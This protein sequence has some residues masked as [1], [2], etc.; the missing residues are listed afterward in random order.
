[1][2]GRRADFRGQG[3]KM[4]GGRYYCV[5]LRGAGGSQLRAALLA[6]TALVAAGLPA[7]AQDAT[8]LAAPI[9]GDYNYPRNWSSGTVPSGTAYF[10]ASN[11]TSLS[12]YPNDETNRTDVG[13][14]T[15]NA[16][17]GNYTFANDQSL[18]FN[19]AGIVINGGS[20]TITVLDG[21]SLNFRNASTTG[22]ATINLPAYS[23]LN[24][25]NT[26]SAGNAAITT[27]GYL[28]F[29]NTSTA[30]SAHITNYGDGGGDGGGIAGAVSFRDSS[31]AG[32]AT[33]TNY[34]VIGFSD[35]STAGSAAITNNGGAAFV[36]FSGASTAG[37]ATITN[38]AH[39]LVGFYG[40]STG[41]NAA[42]IN[43]ASGRVDFSGSTGPAGDSRLS[44]GSIAGAGDFFLGARKLSVGGNNLSTEVSGVI[45]DCSVSPPCYAAGATGGSLVKTGTG[46]LTLSGV[47]TYTGATTV[48]GGIL[49]VDGSIA[50]SALTSVNGGSLL[51]GTGTVGDT[52]VNSGGSLLGGNG[53]AGA[54]LAISGN[55]AFQSG[56][57]YL[58]AV[59]PATAS[60]TSVTG[61][62]TLGGATVNAVFAPRSYISKKY[63]ILTA[64]GG[65]SGTFAAN[66]VNTNLPANFHTALSYDA[67]HAYLDLTLNYFSIPGGLNQNQQAWATR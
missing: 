5:G 18:N 30:G 67:T 55:L 31:T 16:G 44:V 59:N 39:S 57:M 20:A 46:T 10:G 34:G 38:N 53:T 60:F 15:F 14:W 52:T 48:D 40:T 51:M 24:F 33:I 3:R 9:N 26:G 35:T 27:Y 23:G 28:N 25:Y 56:A 65:V 54:S 41:G 11:I 12:L 17:A 37:N 13:G 7:A 49:R 63:T 22:G 2:P 64:N 47:N 6:S 66:P 21:G 8:W 62:A 29:Y 58:V 32:S 43:A 42:I 19:G 61:T 45:S 50:S 36:A 4:F 1:M